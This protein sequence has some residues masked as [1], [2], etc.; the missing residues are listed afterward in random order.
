MFLEITLVKISLDL[1]KLKYTH[2]QNGFYVLAMKNESP[3]SKKA[4]SYVLRYMGRPCFAQYRI[5]DIDEKDFVS[6]CYQRYVD[7]DVTPRFFCG[8]TVQKY[9]IGVKGKIYKYED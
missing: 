3:D 5:I 1:S 9:Y 6:L 4:I 2:S 7:T 8:K